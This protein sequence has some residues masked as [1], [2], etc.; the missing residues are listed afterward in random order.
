MTRRISFKHT[1]PPLFYPRYMQMRR[2]AWSKPIICYVKKLKFTKQIKTPEKVFHAFKIRNVF[3]KINQKIITQISVWLELPWQP[4]ST[5]DV[6]SFSAC[7]LFFRRNFQLQ[8]RTLKKPYHKGDPLGSVPVVKSL[9][10]FLFHDEISS[11]LTV[12]C[13]SLFHL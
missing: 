9:F 5:A 3:K 1:S 6:F 2:G 7:L 13:E 11:Y 8:F 10:S 4:C 12:Y